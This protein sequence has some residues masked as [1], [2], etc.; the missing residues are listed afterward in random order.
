MGR[1][2]IYDPHR[3]IEV[4]RFVSYMF[5]HKGLSHIVGNL[6]MQ[7]LLG[8]PLEVFNGWRVIVVYLCGVLAGSMGTSLVTPDIY[9]VGASAGVYSLLT[10][11]LATIFLVSI[12]SSTYINQQTNCFR[13]GK[14]WTRNIFNFF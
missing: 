6:L 10:A 11:H 2:F 14:R 7:I 5:V 9:L 12:L 1:L 3:R 8:L 13:I 4:W